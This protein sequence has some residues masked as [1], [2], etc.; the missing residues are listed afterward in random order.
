MFSGAA[1]T[2]SVDHI[3]KVHP[4]GGAASEIGGA[5]ARVSG[6]HAWQEGGVAPEYAFTMSMESAEAPQ[7]GE[8]FAWRSSAKTSLVPDVATTYSLLLRIGDVTSLIR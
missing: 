5:R 3:V 8:A 2:E 1:Q 6:C 4:I 7:V